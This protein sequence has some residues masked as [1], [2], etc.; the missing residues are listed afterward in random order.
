MGQTNKIP[1]INRLLEE[2]CRQEDIVYIGIIYEM[3]NRLC[4]FVKDLP[5]AVDMVTYGCVLLLIIPTT[6]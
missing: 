4:R 5:Y 2:Y 6:R 3:V 1:D